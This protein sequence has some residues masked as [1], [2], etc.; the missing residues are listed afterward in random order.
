MNEEVTQSVKYC[1][2]DQRR[3]QGSIHNQC[4]K[5]QIF[6]KPDLSFSSTEILRL[7][8]PT[9]SQEHSTAHQRHQS[10]PNL[11]IT[12]A[13]PFRSW[14]LICFTN[15]HPLSHLH[16]C[17]LR[18]DHALSLLTMRSR[19]GGPTCCLVNTR[20]AAAY[21]MH[22]TNACSVLGLAC[23]GEDFCAGT[24]VCTVLCCRGGVGCVRPT[25][26]DVRPGRAGHLM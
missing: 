23:W 21:E 18:T 1:N 15:P 6:H 9:H 13:T 10:N 26:G 5:E 20:G 25:R 14:H 12:R 17:T 4:N 24:H 19:S 11:H 16:N 7:H 8:G 22:R 3:G 2:H